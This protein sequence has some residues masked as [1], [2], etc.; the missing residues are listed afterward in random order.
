GCGVY[1]LLRELKCQPGVSLLMSMTY[2]SC[3]FIT[4]HLQHF[5]WIT[6]AAAFPFVLYSFLR[7]HR[8]PLLRHLIAGAFCSFF[9]VASTHP[10]LVIGSIYFLLF[11]IISIWLFRK[12]YTSEYCSKNFI[13]RNL[14]FVLTAAVF[15]VVVIASDVDVLLHITRGNKPGHAET[16]LHP[17]T[18]QSYISLLFPLAVNK[19]AFFN[20]DISMRNLYT[21]LAGL[22]GIALFFI[23]PSR[24]LKW[25]ALV[26]LLF[27]ILLA[28]GGPVKSVL[29]NHLP[30]IGYVRLNGEFAYFVVL[31]II[32]IAGLTITQWLTRADWFSRLWK[33][34]MILLAVFVTGFVTAALLISFQRHS[35]TLGDNG[36]VTMTGKLKRVIQSVSVGHLLLVSSFL[37]CVSLILILRATTSPVKIFAVLAANLVVFTWLSLPFTGLGIETKNEIAEKLSSPRGIPAQPLIPLKQSLYDSALRRE[38]VLMGSYKKRIGT[39]V[40]DDYPVQLST[41]RQFF[42]D[43]GMQSFINERPWLFLSADTTAGTATSVGSNDI[44]VLEWGPTH[45]VAEIDNHGFRFLNY[46]QND[47]RY[48]K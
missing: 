15:S 33:Q 8:Q 44:K 20:T 14:V 31:L 36:G 24:R 23:S 45:V 41:N 12:N 27:F 48:W 29:L 32:V 7:F 17:T 42:A 30:L 2:M 16:L 25:A 26:P 38:F 19:S 21:G 34:K 39:P 40:E 11:A 5:C 6:G 13:A 9:F 1:L 4:G 35:V 46:L 37:Q 3:G 10:G 22:V 43:S 47:Y 18:L 28:S